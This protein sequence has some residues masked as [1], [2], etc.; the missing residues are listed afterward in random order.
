MAR[1]AIVIGID[2]YKNA[3][4]NLTGAVNDAIRFAEWALGRGGVEREN[5]RLLL[6]AKQARP[7]PVPYDPA[8]RATIKQAIIDFQKGAGAGGER[9]YFYYGGH[10]LSAPGAAQGAFQEPVLI[11]SD[12]ESLARDDGLLIGFSAVITPLNAA[13]PREQ[14]FFIDACRDFELEDFLP[15]VGN[16]V[17]PW[18]PPRDPQARSK[19]FVLYATAPG[20]RAFERKALGRGVFADALLD[21]LNGKAAG[22]AV[23]ASASDNYEVRFTTLAGHIRAAVEKGV[24]DLAQRERFVQLP[25]PLAIRASDTTLVAFDSEEMGTRPVRIRVGPS[26]ARPSCQISLLFSAPGSQGIPIRQVGPPAEASTKLDVAP[27]DYALQA[28][29]DGYVTERQPCLVYEPK[30]VDLRLS[31]APDAAAA[32]TPDRPPSRS[33]GRRPAPP[34]AARRSRTGRLEITCEDPTALIVVRDAERNARGSGSGGRLGTNLPPGIYRVQMIAVEGATV[35]DVAEV[36]AGET[37]TLEL[38]AP[39][40]RL[41]RDQLAMLGEL[42]IRETDGYLHPSE[43]LDG[44]ANARLASLLAFAAFA[45]HWPNLGDFR[46]LREFGVDHWTTLGAGRA[47]LM[48]LVGASGDHPVGDVSRDRFVSEGEFLAR[49]LEGVTLAQGGFET[50]RGMAAAAQAKTELAAGCITVELSL[51]GLAPTRYAVAALDG[52]VTVLIAVA[53]DDGQVEVQQYLI[54]VRRSPRDYLVQDPKN[55]RWLEVAQRHYAAGAAARDAIPADV[56]FGKWL[57]PLLGCLAGYSLIREDRADEYRGPAM[58]NMLRYFGGLP[59]SHVLAGLCEPEHR[60]SH[61]SEALRLGLPVFAEGFRALYEWYR[62]APRPSAHPLWVMPSLLLPGSPWTTWVASR[63]VLEVRR[64]RF[65]AAP[66]GWAALERQRPAIES[67]ARSVG[68]VHAKGGMV[69]TGFVIAPGVFATGG[70][71]LLDDD[72]RWTPT[73]VDFGDGRRTSRS[74]EFEVEEVIDVLKV[75]DRGLKLLRLAPRSRSG[76]QPPPPLELAAQLETP[77]E[78]RQVYVVGYP[79][80]DPRVPEEIQSRV[81]GGL[82]GVKRVQPGQLLSLAPKGPIFQHDC[83]TLGGNG[84]SPVV[85]LATGRVIGIHYGGRWVDFKLGEALALWTLSRR[86]ALRRVRATFR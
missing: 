65:G 78:G 63:P 16:A 74:L 23:W 32:P 51:P 71:I 43:H 7:T 50:L 19:Q 44:F 36:R 2:S 84:G 76:R 73:S 8:D 67:A 42:G 75:G 34:A 5:L 52:R 18:S 35:D 22:S 86:Q 26:K 33:P 58:R 68:R 53:E 25:E 83:F 62:A 60:D 80:H 15:G 47:G 4:W 6:S 59:D 69:G 70:M 14:F 61:F 48:L 10:G 81:L 56:L 17:G 46:R 55:I 24:G 39:G 77:A 12:V 40:P 11:P 20:L 45:A 38:E 79:Q 66:A 41:G 31:P 21:A 54:P 13:E 9:L 27:G 28:A 37:T 82:Y 85:D 64:G 1:F 57:D 29:A 3:S 30:T 49:D 72:D